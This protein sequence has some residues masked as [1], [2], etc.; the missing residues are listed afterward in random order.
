MISRDTALGAALGTFGAGGQAAARFWAERNAGER[1]TLA[2]GGVV[3]ALI[4]G[5]LVLVQPAMDGL[6]RLRRELPQLQARAA[7]VDALVVQARHLRELPAAAVPATADARA[8]LDHS[9]A[10]AGLRPVHR[11]QTGTD[12]L[13]LRFH[14]VPYANWTIWLAHAQSALKVRAVAVT[15]TALTTP[16]NAD[17]DCTLR[18]PSP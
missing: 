2:A 13:Q 10:A 9:L 4:A 1:R 8:A 18:L 5:Y 12:M 15:A 7:Q 6:G 14:D 17:I 3:L 16:G 11:A